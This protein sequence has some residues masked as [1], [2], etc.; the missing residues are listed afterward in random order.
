MVVTNTIHETTKTCMPL[1]DLDLFR[2]IR[3]VTNLYTINL[4]SG[5]ANEDLTKI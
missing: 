2:Q 4:N 3:F 5:N 1:D